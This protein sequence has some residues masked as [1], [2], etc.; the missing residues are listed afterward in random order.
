MYF[1]HTEEAKS[2]C[3]SVLASPKSPKCQK[4]T[5]LGSEV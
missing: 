1:I 2:S 5:K 3:F 4:N